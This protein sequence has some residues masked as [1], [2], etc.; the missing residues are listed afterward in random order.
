[1]HVCFI[2]PLIGFGTTSKVYALKQNVNKSQV[3]FACKVICKK[4]LSLDKNS[5][6][7]MHQLR[8]ESSILKKLNHQNIVQ[9]Y[10]VIETKNTLFIV[11]EYVSGGELFHHIVNNGPLSE[12]A[13]QKVVKGVF[14]AVEYLHERGFIHR[15]IKAE[16]ILFTKHPPPSKD[17]DAWDVK[18]IDFGFSK[19]SGHIL[20]PSISISILFF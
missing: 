4:R 13:T 16:N 12:V 14:S 20:L 3:P 7:V 19:R 5:E 1:M 18:I 11:M 17:T 2:G 15:D 8:S 6:L 9:V 10:D